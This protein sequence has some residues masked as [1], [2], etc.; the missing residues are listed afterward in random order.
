MWSVGPTRF[1]ENTKTDLPSCRETLVQW[2]SVHF[3]LKSLTCLRW[4]SL[5]GQP[6]AHG[7]QHMVHCGFWVGFPYPVGS[8]KLIRFIY[9]HYHIPSLSF[10]KRP[11]PL[12]GSLFRSPFIIKVSFISKK[13][14]IGL[15]LE[16]FLP[17]NRI[18]FFCKTQHY[19][20]NN[21]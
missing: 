14:K 2:K 18:F 12:F 21:N 6:T 20:E 13:T 16:S 10:M 19:M 4:A 11:K 9:L 8:D 1:E 17:F 15:F 5:G 7:G 3:A